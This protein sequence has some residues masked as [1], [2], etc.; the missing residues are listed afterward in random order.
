MERVK[1]GVL[2]A[3]SMGEVHVKNLIQIPEAEIK[4]ICDVS[5]PRAEALSRLCKAKVYTDFNEMLEKEELEV[6]YILLPPFAQNGQFEQAAEK[7]IHIFIEK[8]IAIA[9]DRGKSMVDAAKKAKIKSH[10][11]F[12]MRYG[13]AIQKLKEMIDDGSAGRPVLFNGRYQCNSLHV[14]WWRDVNLC[15]GQIFEQAIHVYDICRYM[16][17][18]PKAV[19][20]FMGNVCH[21]DVRGYTVEDVSASVSTFTTGAQA[22]IT[23]NNCSVPNRWDALFDMIYQNVSVFF[24]SQ[25]EAEFHFLEDGEERV[26]YFN[27]P[28]DHKLEEDR[29]FIRRVKE[30]LPSFCPVDE[31]LRS[32]LYVEAS[33]HS[34]KMDGQ[35]MRVEIY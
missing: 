30:D 3:G 24:K 33:L 16:F 10:V 26:E 23:A 29:D 2:G 17:G 28:I 14:D 19:A 35:K 22:A 12:H 13:T 9:S 11:G 20:S 32:L 18:H 1:V 34:A 27:E 31:G 8:P 6:L 5:R 15:G 25:D 7:G 4:A 21:A